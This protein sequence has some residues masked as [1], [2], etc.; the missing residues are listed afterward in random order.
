M[1]SANRTYVYSPVFPLFPLSQTSLIFKGKKQN[2]YK[3]TASCSQPLSFPS[4]LWQ[5]LYL[6]NLPD[7][8]LSLFVSFNIRS[9]FFVFFFLKLVS[10][11][12]SCLFWFISQTLMRSQLWQLILKFWTFCEER[13]LCLKALINSVAHNCYIFTNRKGRGLE[14]G[15]ERER[16]LYQKLRG[17]SSQLS[18][19]LIYKVLNTASNCM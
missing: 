19:N 5:N 12:F 11:Q 14:K 7:R 17:E 10:W 16:H 15:R 13:S 18:S 8:Q 1:I 3:L 4:S 6:V 9:F 2:S